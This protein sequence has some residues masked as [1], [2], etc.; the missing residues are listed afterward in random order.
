MSNPSLLT[1]ADVFGRGDLVDVVE[2]NLDAT[3]ALLL[4]DGHVETV[5]SRRQ[6]QREEKGGSAPS[7]CHCAAWRCGEGGATWPGPPGSRWRRASGRP[8]TRPP[9]RCSTRASRGRCLL[10][11]SRNGRAGASSAMDFVRRTRDEVTPTTTVRVVLTGA[12]VALTVDVSGAAV[13]WVLELASLC[14]AT[15]APTCPR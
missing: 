6:D 2:R 5:L 10:P 1:I 7:C 12:G 15:T 11:S 14:A 3:L 8:G 4:P 13:D 9:G